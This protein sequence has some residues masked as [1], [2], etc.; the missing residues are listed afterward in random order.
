MAM[1]TFGLRFLG[2]GNAQAPDL[3]SS[4][5]VLEVDGRPSLLV[6]CGPDTI[7]TF[8]GIY[9]GLPSALFITHAH[10]DHI[11]GLEG[12]FYRVATA[13]AALRPPKVY[14][15][16]P[17]LQVMQSRLADYPNIL[18]EGGSNFWDAFQLIPVSD[19]FWHESL[20]FSVFPVRHHEYLSA[21]G[22]ALAGRFLYTGDTRPIPEVLSRYA[23]RGELIFHDCA[24]RANPSHTGV[25]DIARE[26]QPEQWQR[27]VLYHYES[28]EAGQA[29][30]ERGYR[31]ARRGERYDLLCPS[32]SAHHIPGLSLS[33]ILD[34][35]P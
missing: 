34:P 26:Y 21:F 17:L 11:G 4:S 19:R 18:A 31:I 23:A 27:M 24:S 22:L 1:S 13:A 14:C 35:V 32:Q 8:L 3:G 16:V 30:E 33:E 29:I 20:L 5:A 15:P 7:D 12:L 25:E 9:A 2:V 28:P 10:M 6:D